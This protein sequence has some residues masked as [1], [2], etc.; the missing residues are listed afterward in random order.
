MTSLDLSVMP[1]CVGSY[2][3]VLDSEFVEK[4]VYDMD[5]PLPGARSEER[6]VGKECRL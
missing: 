2:K 3:L 6:R 1:R 5:F 4:F